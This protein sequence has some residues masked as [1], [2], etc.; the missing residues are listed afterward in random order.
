MSPFQKEE[1]KSS[2]ELLM[3]IQQKDILWD[4]FLTSMTIQMIA[5]SISPILPLLCASFGTKR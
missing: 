4:S 3:S 2:W 5:Q 1:Q